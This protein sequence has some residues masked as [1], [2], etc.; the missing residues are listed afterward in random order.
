MKINS[1]KTKSMMVSRSWTYA[2]SY[3]DL[4]LGGVALDKV[5]A[6]RI[7][8]VTFDSKLTFETHLRE[9]VSKAAMSLGVVHRAGKLFD[10]RRMLKSCF[11][12][13]ILSNLKYCASCECRLLSLI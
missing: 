12:A 11:S 8:G 9:V 6:L 5:R 13:Y 10:C 1:K 7:L 4:T 2:P 3:G